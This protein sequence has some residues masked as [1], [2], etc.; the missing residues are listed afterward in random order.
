MKWLGGGRD[1][2]GVNA[3]SLEGGMVRLSGGFGIGDRREGGG[4]SSRIDSGAVSWYGAKFI[5]LDLIFDYWEFGMLRS[6][7][8]LTRGF[9]NQG[10]RLKM[11][12]ILVRHYGSTGYRLPII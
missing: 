4:D 1:D 3:E 2:A 8:Y 11:L 5:E 9:P 12:Y 7:E 10:Q 6:W